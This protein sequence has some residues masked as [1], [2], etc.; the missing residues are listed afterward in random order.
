MDVILAHFSVDELRKCLTA[1]NE[2]LQHAET[3]LHPALD[4]LKRALSVIRASRKMHKASLVLADESPDVSKAMGFCNNFELY[5]YLVKEHEIPA[6]IVK[7]FKT[8]LDKLRL[9]LDEWIIAVGIR[10]NGLT[11]KWFDN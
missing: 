1:V 2:E 9:E 5:N 3:Q 7:E 10:F 8:K 11:I 6:D 4:V